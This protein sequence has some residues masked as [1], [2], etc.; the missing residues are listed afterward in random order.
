MVYQW[1]GSKAMPE[2]TK[3]AVPNLKAYSEPRTIKV[4]VNEDKEPEKFVKCVIVDGVL[5]R[6]EE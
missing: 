2:Q 1:K 6:R 4:T 5:R 3:A